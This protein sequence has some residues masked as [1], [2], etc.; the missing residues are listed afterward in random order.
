MRTPILCGV[1]KR[2]F[3][4][5]YRAD[6]KVVEGLLPAPFSPKL[7]HGYAI[8]GVCLDRLEGVRLRGLPGWLGVSSE[9]AVH[10]IAAEWVDSQGQSRES[11]YAA[12]RDTNLWLSAPLGAQLFSR[13]YHRA[14]F[15][16]EES[17]GHVDFAYRALDRTA[18]VN[19]SGDDAFKLPP[20]SCFKSLQE[21]FFG[22]GNSGSSP[23][24]DQP[25]L[26]GIAFETKE[27][28]IR[29]F[30][31]SRLFSSFF[32]DKERFPAGTIEF[33]HAL[34]I[35]DVAHAWHFVPSPA[36]TRA[37]PWLKPIE[38]TSPVTIRRQAVRRPKSA[39]VTFLS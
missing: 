28:K 24:E 17:V 16:V 33:D 31:V 34:V 23:A 39:A 35:R 27:W 18:E 14:R 12:R 32:D 2:R 3:V 26:H 7:Y 4:L 19:F 36:D 29:P 38:P 20:S 9:N 21:E 13:G 8:V 1:I 30:Q 6:P 22:T 25:N 5:N 15:A 37:H 10:R 11:V